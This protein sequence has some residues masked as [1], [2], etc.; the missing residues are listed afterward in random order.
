MP[1]TR[2]VEAHF[3]KN[4][5]KKVEITARVA[6]LLE[7]KFASDE[8]FLDCFLVEIALKP[9]NLLEI[10]IDADGAMDF[11][12]C[13][14]IS[15][16]VEAHLDENQWLGETYTLEVSSPGIGRPLKFVRQFVKN[17]GR[18]LELTLENGEIEEGILVSADENAAVL[19]QQKVVVE[20]KKKKKTIEQT[21]FEHSKIKKAIVQITF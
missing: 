16:F 10:F 7:E 21:A 8:A 4:A 12:R 20:G 14:K 15:R 5:S 3:F 1:K 13:Q 9:A 11:A 6:Q 18:T 19:E 17:V 2:R